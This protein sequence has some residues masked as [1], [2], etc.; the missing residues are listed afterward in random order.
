MFIE[1]VIAWYSVSDSGS[2]SSFT[3][4]PRMQRMDTEGSTADEYNRL[5]DSTDDVLKEKER[6]RKGVGREG[7]RRR[8]KESTNLP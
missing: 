4:L 3:Y 7:E 2:I 6:R 1:H 5:G 8:K